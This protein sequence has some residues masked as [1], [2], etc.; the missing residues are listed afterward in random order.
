MRVNS[1]QQPSFGMRYLEPKAWQPEVLEALMSSN[2]VKEIDNKYPHA[3][4]SFYKA[5][6]GGL[7]SVIFELND[8][9][10]I[11][12][13]A[14][15]IYEQNAVEVLCKKIKNLKLSH[16][17]QHFPFLTSNYS[18]EMVEKVIQQAEDINKIQDKAENFHLFKALKRWFL[19]ES[20]E[21]TPD[22]KSNVLRMSQINI[23][24]NRKEKASG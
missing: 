2:I 11:D 8:D 21:M 15:S 17:E 4:A 14:C 12:A 13:V 23:A 10:K 9:I 1:T 19:G 24:K 20:Y 22:S 6:S 5:T 16:I 3:I 18:Q 7:R